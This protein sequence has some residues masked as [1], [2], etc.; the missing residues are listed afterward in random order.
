MCVYT[1]TTCRF[2]IHSIKKIKQTIFTTHD[3]V[4][5]Y[6]G[7]I[8][9]HVCSLDGG[10]KLSET[11]A[12]IEISDVPCYF[13]YF[14]KKENAEKYINLNSPKYS[15]KDIVPIVNNWSMCGIEEKHILNFL[16]KSENNNI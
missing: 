14:A 12:R 15:I 5:V 13:H 10:Y 9:Y 4:E 3:N 8:I 2:T 7:E 6:D 11:V 16:A 1:S